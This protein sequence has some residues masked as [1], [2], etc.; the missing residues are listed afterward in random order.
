MDELLT[1]YLQTLYSLRGGRLS[2]ADAMD[3]VL[4]LVSAAHK[5]KTAFVKLLALTSARTGDGK[6]ER[7]R[8]R[9]LQAHH[10]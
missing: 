1:A 10:A 3:H 8:P 9:G 4:D 5:G 6:A 7:R 2:A